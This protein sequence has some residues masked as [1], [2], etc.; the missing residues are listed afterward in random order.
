MAG[1]VARYPVDDSPE[2]LAAWCAEVRRDYGALVAPIAAHSPVPRLLGA[3]WQLL[4]ATMVAPGLVDRTTKEAVAAAVSHANSCWYG[5][6]LH[7]TVLESLNERRPV[8]S[9]LASLADRRTSHIA[10]WARR[11]GPRRPFPDRHAA[12]I[13]GTVVVTHYLN[14]ITTALSASDTG[15]FAAVALRAHEEHD[16]PT[17]RL[18]GGRVPAGFAWA[19]GRQDIAAAFGRAAAAVD[20]AAR[21]V[22][23][24]ARDLVLA[25]LA[26]WQ[27]EAPDQRLLPRWLRGLPSEDR[28]TG[29]LALLTAVAPGQLDPVL[30]AT[31][32]AQ[33]GERGLVEVAGWASFVAA[34]RIGERL[35]PVRSMVERAPGPHQVLPFRPSTSRRR[36][37]AGG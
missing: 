25:K 27:G 7:L 9:E 26:T 19:A 32:R 12:E 5:E 29:R 1:A 10:A 17:G 21:A 22:P 8:D 14:R 20:V 35:A 28:L 15:G 13:V 4:R 6:E 11:P 33:L 36:R 34:R 31:C 24:P 3:A 16:V 30:L 23:E 2:S 18:A 37:R